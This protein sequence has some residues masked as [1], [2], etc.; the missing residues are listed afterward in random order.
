MR[1]WIVVVDK[2]RARVFGSAGALSA[3]TPVETIMNE[4]ADRDFRAERSDAAGRVY[5]RMGGGRHSVSTEDPA[6][7]ESRLRF[8]RSVAK[9]LDEGRRNGAYEELQLV[10]GAQLLGLL[11]ANLSGPTSRCVTIS[12]TKDLV[13]EDLRAIREHLSALSP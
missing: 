12:L 6:E 10:A 7:S 5:D 3:M 13:H 1:K 4:D 2:N 8:I 11:R 9:R